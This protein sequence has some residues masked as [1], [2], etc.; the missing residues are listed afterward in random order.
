[1]LLLVPL[2]MALPVTASGGLGVAE[3]L[4]LGEP[5]TD[6]ESGGE[7]LTLELNRG[8]ILS[9]AL[10]TPEPVEFT[11]GLSRGVSEDVEVSVVERVKELTVV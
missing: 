4:R 6:W 2:P 9:L 3:P 10:L 7:A 5:L 1:M 8:V 11:E